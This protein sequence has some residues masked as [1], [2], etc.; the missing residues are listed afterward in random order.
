MK[1]LLFI[2]AFGLLSTL[3]LSKA[4]G[5]TNTCSGTYTGTAASCHA[6]TIGNGTPGYIRVCIT[7]NNIPGGNCNP[8]GACNPPFNGGGHPSRIAIYASNGTTYTG[9]ALSSFTSTTA[10]GT[11]FIVST[12]NGYATIFGLC[13]GSGT[14]ISWTTI[15]SCGDQV[16]T[17]TPPPCTGPPCATCASACGTCGFET[18]PAVQTVVDN[19]P[20]YNFIPALTS[21]QSA[22]RC[23]Q[24]TAVNSTVSFGVIIS[25]TCSSGNVSNFS[26]TLQ[27]S[28]CGGIIQSGTLSSLSFTGLNIGQ[29]YTFCYSFTVPSPAGGCSHTTHYP[30]FVGASTV[31]LPIE[32]MYFTAK[33]EKESNLISWGTKT[34]KDNAY[35]SVEYSSDGFNWNLIHTEQGAGTSNVPI[36]YSANHRDFSNDINYYRLSQTDY[37]GTSEMFNIIS[38]NNNSSLTLLKTLNMYGQVVNDNYQ[39]LVIEY[40]SDGTTMKIFR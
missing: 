26:W 39:G 7:T 30:Y 21:G 13:M 11:C 31:V 15:N 14:T 20:S 32:L 29:T 12:M 16:C 2:T 17:G 24:F 22:T 19:C 28:T 25:S 9:A 1:T 3:S 27:S 34:E 10:T 33:K 40:Y 6:I 4:F 35:F 18:N 8:G 38:I 5:Q 23:H 37:D 36:H